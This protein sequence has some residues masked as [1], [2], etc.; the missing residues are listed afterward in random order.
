MDSRGVHIL[1]NFILYGIRVKNSCEQKKVKG[2]RE[3]ADDSIPKSIATYDKI[4]SVVDK[5]DQIKKAYKIDHR[6]KFKYYMQLLDNMLDAMVVNS[7][8]FT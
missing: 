2:R 6:Y 3:K 7:F 5:S 8:Y 4:M 1:S